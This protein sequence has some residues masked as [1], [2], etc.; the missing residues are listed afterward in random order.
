MAKYLVIGNWKMNGNLS[1]SEQLVED[2]LAQLP[3]LPTLEVAVCPPFTYLAPVAKRLRDTAVKLGA[4]NLCE[5]SAGA[6]TGEVAGPMLA[7]FGT[8]FVLVGHSERRSL[9]GESSELVAAKVET[10]LECVL[11]PVLCVGETL[12]EREAGKAE[13]VISSQLQ[14]VLARI[15]SSAMKRVVI[16]YEPVWAIGTGKTASPQ[17][18]QDIHAFIRTSLQ[19]ADAWS[20]DHSRLL[21]GGSVKADNAAELFGQ[22]D[23]HG[24]LVGGASLKA[25]DFVAICHAAGQ[26]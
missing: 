11:T 10:A 22:A 1:R 19:Q 17:Q 16:A 25:E 24:A 23:I 6:Y 9:Y 13:A 21:Y 12:E 4:Q 3:V 14:P 5:H 18:A 7:D 26:A 15:G 8:R 2:I 20:D